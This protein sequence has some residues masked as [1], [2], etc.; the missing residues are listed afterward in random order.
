MLDKLLPETT[1]IRRVVMFAGVRYREFLIKPLKRH[2]I[3][4]VVPMAT[5]TRGEQLAWLSEDR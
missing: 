2:G 4:V 5:L 3:K 1:G